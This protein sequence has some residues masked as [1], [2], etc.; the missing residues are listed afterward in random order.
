M[1]MKTYLK[2]ATPDEREELAKKVDSSVA[3]FYQIAGRHKKP[4]TALCKA[5]VEAEPKLTLHGL[6][7]DVWGELSIPLPA[8]AITSPH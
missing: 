6:R 8:E 4:G 7:P 5:L 1:D 3:Y 2:Q